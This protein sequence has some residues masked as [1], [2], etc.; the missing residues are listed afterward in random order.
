MLELLAVKTPKL[1]GHKLQDWLE[2]I[3]HCIQQLVIHFLKQGHLKET[4]SQAMHLKLLI[5]ISCRVSKR[6]I[7]VSR[8]RESRRESHSQ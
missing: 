7:C 6:S 3:A 2:A 8:L 4:I 5:N 1:R